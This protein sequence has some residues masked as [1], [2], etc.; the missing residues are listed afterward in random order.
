MKMTLKRQITKSAHEAWNKLTDKKFASGTASDPFI[1]SPNLYA[2]ME[3]DGYDMT[4]VRKARPIPLT[5]TT[6]ETA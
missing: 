1:V 5:I 6:R 4:H 2:A 3:A